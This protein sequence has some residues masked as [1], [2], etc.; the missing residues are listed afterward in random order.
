MTKLSRTPHILGGSGSLR[1][2][3][4]NDP[5]SCGYLLGG[6]KSVTY[7]IKGVT[8]TYAG[9]VSRDDVWVS[10]WDS[11]GIGSATESRKGPLTVGFVDEK[12][13]PYC[14]IGPE[15][16]FG[17]VVGN[18]LTDKVLLIKTPWDGK[19]L[20][21]DFRPP[22]SGDTTGPYCTEMLAKVRTVLADVKKYYPAYDGKGFEIA[23]LRWY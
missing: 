15:F 3:V 1:A 6:T 12:V 5:N 22:S 16:G 4:N 21:V 8:K 20:A 7:T 23:G 11:G 10:S 14:Y 17:H 9:W 19:S 18:G 2:T 13:L